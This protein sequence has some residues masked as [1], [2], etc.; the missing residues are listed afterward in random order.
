MKAYRSFLLSGVILG[1]GACVSSEKWEGLP[2]GQAAYATVPAEV[3]VNR[4]DYRISPQDKLTI[5]VFREPDM[6]VEEAPVETGGS[7]VL[8]LVGRVQAA[9]KTTA[10]LAQELESKLGARFLV[11]PRVSVIVAESKAQSVTVD[12]AVGMPGVYGLQ[13]DTTLLQ[14]I[15]LA[16][17]ATR[18]ATFDKVAVFRTVEGQRQGALFDIAAIR[19]GQAPD[20]VLQSGD[21]VVVGTSGI[22]SFGYDL[23][24]LAPAAGLFVPLVN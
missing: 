22:K 7:L 15:A 10:A 4:P 2:A 13:G 18:V 23:L 8:P 5:T 11:D 20:P 9:G 24:A 16:R 6:S 3:P 17:G 1:L 14:A 12:G 19:A 21:Y